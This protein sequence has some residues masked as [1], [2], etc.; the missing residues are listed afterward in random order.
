MH[1]LDVILLIWRHHGMY[2]H[3]YV[4]FWRWLCLSNLVPR[5]STLVVFLYLVAVYSFSW[6]IVHFDD[7]Y[8]FGGKEFILVVH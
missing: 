5:S 1:L 3:R 2:W 7:N 8:L 6:R 4:P